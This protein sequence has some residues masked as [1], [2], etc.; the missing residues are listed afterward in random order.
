MH[1]VDPTLE[2]LAI[3]HTAFG[4][5]LLAA[6]VLGGSALEALH[7]FKLGFYLD[8]SNETRRLLWTLAHAHAALLG[9]VHVAFASSLPRLL[10]LSESGR[11]LASRALLGGAVLLPAGFLLGGVS[12]QHGDPGLMILLSPIGALLVLVAVVVIARG[13]GRPPAD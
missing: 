9:L 5:W 2:S 11:G 13:A 6:A 1:D 10:R 7:A 3:R 12:A 4:W 8:V